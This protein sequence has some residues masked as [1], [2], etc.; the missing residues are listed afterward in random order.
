M[1]QLRLRK[2]IILFLTV[3]EGLSYVLLYK[4]RMPVEMLDSQ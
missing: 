2:L 3:I 4:N 1:L